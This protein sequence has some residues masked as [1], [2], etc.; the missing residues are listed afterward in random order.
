[1]TRAIAGHDFVARFLRQK[2][3][4]HPENQRSGSVGGEHRVRQAPQESETIMQVGKGF[5]LVSGK[6]GACK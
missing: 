2:E 5:R 3:R 1:M 6:S 4:R